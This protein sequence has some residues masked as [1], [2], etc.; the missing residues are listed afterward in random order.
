LISGAK[1]GH[2]CAS[3]SN[4]CPEHRGADHLQGDHLTLSPS[5]PLLLLPIRNRAAFRAQAFESDEGLFVPGDADIALGEEVELEIHFMAEEVRFRIRASVRWI[6]QSNRRNAPQGL[7]LTFLP[8]EIQARAQL[9]AF[10][11]GDG[12]VMR[13]R[14]GRRL[15]VHVEAKVE[16]EKKSIVV[17]TDDI[18]TGG[19]FLLSSELPPIGSPVYVRLKGPGALFSWVSQ[20]AVV[21]W[22]RV[23]ADRH[24]FGVRFVMGGDR[25]RRRI[26]K[27]M[28]LIRERVSR[29]VH[30]YP[31]R[32]RSTPPTAVASTKPT[33]SMMPRK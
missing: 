14:D 6:R 12:A 5:R 21:C 10:V 27:L 32:T 29:E 25:D 15:P 16:L 13:E 11:D 19:C 33:A 2:A 31:P 7:G 22:H 3:T 28:A 24:G 18:S 26:E 8:T 9:M 4:S 1:S 23:G 30:L 20:N 17:Q